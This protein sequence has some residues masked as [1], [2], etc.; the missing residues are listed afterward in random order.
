LK[1]VVLKADASVCI[2]IAATFT[3]EPVAESIQ[4]WL[5]RLELPARIEFAP[6]NQVLP[7]LLDPGSVFAANRDGLNVILLRFEDWKR[8]RKGGDDFSAAAGEQNR[9]LIAALQ[10]AASTKSAPILVC[11][12]PPSP[13][14]LANQAMA[15]LWNRLEQELESALAGLPAIRWLSSMRLRE[16]YPVANHYDAAADLLGHMPYTPEAYAA[17]GTAIIRV[18]HA[19]R[20]TPYKAIV[21]DCDNTLWRGICG[22]SGPAGVEIDSASHALQTFVKARQRE[23][24]LLCICSKNAEEDVGETFEA[25]PEMPLRR[26]DFVG[27]R[28]N[29]QSKA[30]NIRSLAAE[31]SLGLDSFIFLDDNPMETAEVEARC[32]GVLALTLPAELDPIPRFLDHIWAF[33][34][35]GITAEDRRRTAMYRENAERSRVMA[36]ANSYADFLAGLELHVEIREPDGDAEITRAAQMTQRTNQFNFT[37]RRFTEP[38]VRTICRGGSIRILTVSVRDRFGDYGQTGLVMYE[39]ANDSLRVHN[40][41]LSCRVLGKGVE[42]AMLRRLGEIALAESLPAVEIAFLPTPKNAPA[43]DFLRSLDGRYREELESGF[44]C[45][46]P[47]EMAVSVQFSIPE[48]ERPAGPLL[49]PLP[50]APSVDYAWIATHH[51]D[52]AAILQA[53]ADAQ[54]I[55]TASPTQDRPRNESEQRLTRIWE[56]VLRVSPISIHDSFF[57]LGGDSLQAVRILA[58]LE[59]VTQRHLPL[60]TLVE[61][62]TIAKLAELLSRPPRTRPWE[63]L[64]ALKPSGSRTPFFCVHGVGGNVLEF[65]DLARYVDA[66]QPLYG[67][68]AIGLNGTKPQRK[69]TIEGMAE[70]YLREVREFQSEGPYYLGGSSFGGLVAYEMARQVTA[71]GE[72]VALLAMFDTSVPGPLST[73]NPWQLRMQSFW[74]RVMLHWRNVMVLDRRG[75]MAYIRAKFKQLAGRLGQR[76]ALPETIRLVNEAGQ[77]AVE[78]YAP[79]E[80]GGEVTLFRATEQPPWIAAGPT[81]GWGNLAKGGVEIYDTPGHHADLVRYPRARVLGPQLDAAIAKAR[82]RCDAMLALSLPG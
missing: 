39:A 46:F 81:L 71:A 53:V 20:R 15:D 61:A 10:T 38:E 19:A 73:S 48:N 52:A 50:I 35:N 28:V 3:A 76:E 57:D 8:F 51:C 13:R 24:M 31:L 33:D 18:F 59:A 68:Q 79:G 12:C 22:E 5:K 72:T 66:D 40:L 74:Y 36:E 77:W 78:R 21:L 4:Y 64:V 80:Y 32:P 45:R 82:A 41:L 70:H 67:I 42:H 62:P 58:D 49:E 9:E 29:W 14:A 43:R 56:R 2:A 11:V 63:C 23:G 44:R 37:T 34:G 17:L 47:A 7:A 27:W 30:E 1:A 55:R 65:M 60:A 25:H 69:L 16:L 75:R 54:E 6:Y 26:S